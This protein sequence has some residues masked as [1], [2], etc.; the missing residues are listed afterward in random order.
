[1][2][3]EVQLNIIQVQSRTAKH[4]QFRTRSNKV[5]NFRFMTDGVLLREIERDFLLTKYSVIVIDEAH[6]RSVFTDIL[7]GLLSRS[8][9][10][11]TLFLRAQLVARLLA[12]PEIQPPCCY[13]SISL[14]LKCN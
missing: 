3:N 10:N 12:D 8:D 13:P 1:M 9:S 14:G 11:E 4:H 2:L 7:I 6:E 5:L